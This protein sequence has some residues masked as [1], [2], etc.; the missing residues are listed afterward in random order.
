M[1]KIR[2]E[3]ENEMVHSSR[4]RRRRN[5]R[6]DKQKLMRKRICN[7]KENKKNRSI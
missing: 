4:I 6:G 2:D 1:N 7:Y 3:P 5:W